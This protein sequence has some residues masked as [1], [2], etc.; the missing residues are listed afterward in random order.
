MII[1]RRKECEDQQLSV[2]FK[3]HKFGNIPEIPHVK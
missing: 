1:G 2:S 3:I